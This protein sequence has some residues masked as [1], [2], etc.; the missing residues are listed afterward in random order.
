LFRPVT[1]VF[2]ERKREKI[3]DDVVYLFRKDG[4]EY[5]RQAR[6]KSVMTSLVFST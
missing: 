1:P 4:D 3:D 5:T 6:N 2:E